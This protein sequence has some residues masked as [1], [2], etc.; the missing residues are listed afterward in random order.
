MSRGRREDGLAEVAARRREVEDR[1]GA[2]RAAMASETG[3]A[4]RRKGVLT[5][6]LAGA[7]GLALALKRRARR[8]ALS[9]D[10]DSEV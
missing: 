9:A 1:L 8:A 6:L 10:D 4:P 7:V 3:Y 2:L 5:A